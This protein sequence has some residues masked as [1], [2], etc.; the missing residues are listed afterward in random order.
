MMEIFL[1]N[2]TVIL[3]HDFETWNQRLLCSY[4]SD[5]EKSQF[6]AELED[7]HTQLE[8][9]KKAK[10]NSDK[11]NRALEEQLNDFLLYI[12]ATMTRYLYHILTSI[13]IWISKNG[14]QNLIKLF[15]IFKHM[16]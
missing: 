5:K 1:G 8:Q 2:I 3:P 16:S 4:R 11:N 13:W 12:W 14:N 15:S 6:A 9:A 7:L 10:A